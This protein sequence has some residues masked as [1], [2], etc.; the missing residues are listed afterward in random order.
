MPISGHSCS[1]SRVRL[2]FS[3]DLTEVE[4]RNVIECLDA[5]KFRLDQSVAELTSAYGE[6]GYT[7]KTVQYWFH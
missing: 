1:L 7:K 3:L 5:K 6:Q 2:P 4:Q